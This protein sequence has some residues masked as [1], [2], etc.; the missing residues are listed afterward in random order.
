MEESSLE[1]TSSSAA[2]MV[3]RGSL[4]GMVVASR[5]GLSN[6]KRGLA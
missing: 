4:A 1:Y 5:T 2:G 6:P 3:A